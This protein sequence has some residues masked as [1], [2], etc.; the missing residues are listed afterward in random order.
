MRYILDNGSLIEEESGAQDG[1]S[2][3][4][5]R[6]PIVETVSLGQFHASSALPALIDFVTE[7]LQNA[8]I[9]KAEATSEGVYGILVIPDEQDIIH[10]SH[11]LAFHLSE[12]HLTFIEDGTFAQDMLVRL[13]T[14]PTGPI[15]S[16]SHCLYSFISLTIDQDSDYLHSYENHMEQI[17]ES[18]LDSVSSSMNRSILT[19]RRQLV[20]LASYYDSLS[21]MMDALTEN[22]LFTLS[23][24]Q[25]RLFRSL[26]HRA[27]RLLSTTQS[28]KEYSLTLRELY[29]AQIDL[30]QN[31]TMKFLTVVTTVFLPLTLIAGWYGM[32]FSNMPALNSSFGYPIIIAVCIVIVIMEVILFIRKGWFK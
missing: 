6:P 28:L 9:C 4:S 16:L 5:D 14:L 22:P 15:D 25:R 32:N 19:I 30:R 18:I 3:P 13:S 24:A 27:D 29:Q 8:R 17:E 10:R 11:R 23:G 20:V 26:S 1:P 12:D 7:S 2:H 21:D 31:Q